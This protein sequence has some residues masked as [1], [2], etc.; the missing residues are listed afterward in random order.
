MT[1]SW[2]LEPIRRIAILDTETTGLDPTKDRCIEIA[3]M[4]YDVQHAAPI[5]S[6]ASLIQSGDGNAAEA[7][8]GIKPAM[9]AEA[10]PAETV[11]RAVKWLIAPATLIVAHKAEFDRDFV[12]DFG[13]P[14]VCSKVDIK[15]PN[16][17]RGEH[18]VQL[19][20][21][22]GLGVA[23]AHRASADVDTLARI[24]T[25]C[26]EILDKTGM[27][28]LEGML[29]HACRPKVK[30]IAEV[31]YDDRELAKQHGF[32]WNKDAKQWYRFMPP[33]DIGELPFRV[34]T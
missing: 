23:S 5:A 1:D 16:K 19:A 13:K 26:A 31:S 34:H 8:N 20:L 17:M 6:F 11:W 27:H 30:F 14:W 29:R 4:L 21:G 2:G 3:V 12:P 32:S 15:W 25:R 33:D 9:V 7:I 28:D 10:Q 24:F 22:L 18:L